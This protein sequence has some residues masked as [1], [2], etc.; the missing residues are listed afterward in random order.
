VQVVTV[1]ASKGLEFPVVHVPFGWDRHVFEPD[2]PLFHEDGSGRRVRNVGGAGSDGFREG[3][4]RHQIE[5]FGEDLRLLYVALTRAQCQV[6]AWWAPSSRN[7][8]RAP[9]HRMLFAADPG[10]EVPER[11]TVPAPAV[12]ARRAASRA[13][14]GCLSVTVVPDLDWPSWRPAAVAAAPLAVAR[15]RRGP[16]PS[17]RRTSYSAL[18]AGVHEAMIGSEPEADQRDDEPDTA[19]PAAEP[20]ELREVL[21]PLGA[22]PGGTAFGTLVHAVLEHLDTAAPDL[23]GE[24]GRQ[25]RTQHARLGPAGV[26]PDEL[27]AALLPA[28]GTP[29]GPLAGDR[30][31]RDIPPADRLVELDF[32]LPLAGGDRPVGSP[33]L[34]DL[35]ALLREH[36]PAAD[37]LLPYAE[38]LADPVVGPSVLRGYLGGSIDAL[39]RVADRYIVV[40]Y[41]TNRLGTPDAPLSAWDYRAPAMAQ[42]MLQAHYPLQALLYDVAVHRFLRWRLRSYDPARHLGGVLY[43]FLR[44]MCGPQ[45]QFTDGTVPGVFAW[46]PPVSLV[47]AAS[48]LLAGRRP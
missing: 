32:E 20:G 16:H 46:R 43:L 29:L 27:A 31:L 1:H 6:T 5:E 13:V 23:A 37:P 22:F 33:R 3:Q 42:A 14:P 2:I 19:T 45:V 38:L 12:A 30:S 11:L 10:V 9:L 48:D 41:K 26:H 47:L 24:L 40:D 17:W 18:T 4:R 7:T 35:A 25:V 15:L 34:A 8:P 36:L 28:L 44:G 21:S 39:L